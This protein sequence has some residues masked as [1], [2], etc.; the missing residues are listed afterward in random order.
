MKSKKLWIPV[1]GC[2]CILVVMFF[3]IC[4]CVLAA[5]KPKPTTLVATEQ[6][7]FGDTIVDFSQE[8]MD[9]PIKNVSGSI[10]SHAHPL[11]KGVNYQVMIDD[12]TN[13]MYTFPP[14]D[15]PKSTTSTNMFNYTNMWSIARYRILPGQPKTTGKFLYTR[16]PG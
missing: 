3:A 6:L 9:E 5:A 13:K 4:V 15:A 10:I 12:D 2:I 8:W 11:T 7:R 16:D 14:I 1:L